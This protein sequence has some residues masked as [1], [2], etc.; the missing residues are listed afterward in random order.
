MMKRK[1]RREMKR[2]ARQAAKCQAAL[3]R[4]EAAVEA[5]TQAIRRDGHRRR[6]ALTDADLD[7]IGDILIEAGS[8]IPPA[9]YAEDTPAQWRAKIRRA[10]DTLGHRGARPWWAVT[11]PPGDL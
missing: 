10:L 3:A 11:R 7:F 1:K 8:H 4:A 2:A 9:E 6:V 5:A